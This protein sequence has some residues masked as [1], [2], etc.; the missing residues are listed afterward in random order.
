MARGRVDYNKEVN[1]SGCEVKHLIQNVQL[2]YGYG[3][4]CPICGIKCIYKARDAN[5]KYIPY[6]VGVRLEKGTRVEQTC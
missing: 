2:V 5:Q 3:Y 4:K 1:C 6:L